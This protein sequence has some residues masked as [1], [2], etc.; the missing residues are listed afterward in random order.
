MLK[1][2]VLDT[3]HPSLKT[4][5][6]TGYNYFLF[7]LPVH[8]QYPGGC[9]LLFPRRTRVSTY[10]VERAKNKNRK[11]PDLLLPASDGTDRGVCTNRFA[12]GVYLDLDDNG[13]RC[14]WFCRGG[15]RPSGKDLAEAS[16]K[17]RL[18][19]SGTPSLPVVV[20][21]ISGVEIRSHP[22][23]DAA[24]PTTTVRYGTVPY[25]CVCV[26]F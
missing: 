5:T 20:V 11:Q 6:T 23:P 2:R 24:S 17:N 8:Q 1:T 19:S 3:A 18:F 22:P 9:Y 13:D 16:P 21:A 15:S 7:F 10:Y 14:L 26:I 12:S 25:G 4:A